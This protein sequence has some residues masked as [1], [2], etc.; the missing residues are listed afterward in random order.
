M[1][2][3]ALFD[4]GADPVAV[5]E[6]VSRL[7]VDGW[8]LGAERVMRNGLAATRALVGAPDD[9]DH[10][11]PYRSIR[12]LVEQADLPPWVRDRALAAFAAL[13]EAEGALH[14]VDPESVEFHEVGALDA[15]VDIV[16]TCAAL[17]VLGIDHIVCS[18]IS[19]GMG[20]IRAVHGLL[21]NPAPAVAELASRRGVPLVG[22]DESLELATPTGVAL[23]ASLASSFGPLP[24]G[25]V[26]ATGMGA[27]GRDTPARPNVVQV[28]IVE[29]MA[30]IESIA[31]ERLVVAETN[32][33]DVTGEV[34][35][36][37]VARLLAEGALDAWV[38]PIV[39]KKGR[40]AHTLHALCPPVLLSRLCD[41]MMAETGTL[42]VRCSTVD[43]LAAPRTTDTVVVG[44]HT[45]RIKR[46]GARVK[47]EHDDAAAAAAVLDR[48]L[49]DVL[50]A[51]E[52]AGL[53]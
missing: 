48:P 24:A 5:T 53:S 49:R 35:A 32:L 18:P 14:G 30:T 44:G 31:T 6:I 15:I 3:G 19:V 25:R 27:G 45:I 36:H 40:P 12:A 22:L 46:S 26:V 42:G 50:A 23:M 29:S 11:R 51:A 7:G 17:E 28:L 9:H 1:A 47:V 52:Q 33:D 43:R 16:G 41:V 38:T 34:L 13:A 4:A 10:H 20:T 2:L 8:S 37:A 39:M 21:P